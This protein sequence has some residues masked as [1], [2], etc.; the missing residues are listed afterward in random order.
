[1]GTSGE[2]NRLD[3]RY[4]PLHTKLINLHRPKG[5]KWPESLAFRQRRWRCR[6]G[7]TRAPQPFAAHPPISHKHAD[8]TRCVIRF[9]GSLRD[10]RPTLVHLTRAHTKRC[11][12]GIP[13]D[14]GAAGRRWSRR[15][16]GVLT[17]AARAISA[18]LLR[19]PADSAP[20]LHF[21]PR[22]H[23]HQAACVCLCFWCAFSIDCCRLHHEWRIGCSARALS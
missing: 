10:A 2:S 22:V 19:A 14:L 4:I 9:A 5:R 16:R 13:L 7:V 12:T 17:P 20:R 21:F 6:L 1:M 15:A 23:A 8:H 11:S 3:I 18:H